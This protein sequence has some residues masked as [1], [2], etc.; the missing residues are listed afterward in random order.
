MSTI[1]EKIHARVSDPG[2][3]E[4]VTEFLTALCA[5]DTTPSADV[6]QMR[7][8]ESRAFDLIEEF[9]NE[10][11]LDEEFAVI[12]T[13][14]RPIDPAIAQNPAFS[15]LHF[16]KTEESP[17]GLSPEEVYAK[18]TNL[19]AF[20][21]GA[22]DPDG[23]DTAINAH[24]DVIAP[25]IPPRRDG[26]T[27]YG[28]G[29]V[30]DKGN[31]AAICAAL[32]VIQEMAAVGDIELKNKITAMFPVEEETGGNGSLA[33][34]MDRELRKRYDSILI[35]E[36]AGG[37]IFP[38]N[39]G[40]VWFKCG[41]RM[42]QAEEGM[43][44]SLLYAAAE[45]ILAMSE[46]GAKI[47]A[48]SDH[49]LFPHRPVQTCNGIL[50]PYGE[51]PS[52]INGYIKARLQPVPTDLDA[53][54]RRETNTP[55]DLAPDRTTG[56]NAPTDLAS[57]R[58]TG[59]NAPTDL[60]SDRTSGENAPTDL[61]P[62]R[63]TGE[64]AP[65]D[66]APVERKINSA[67]HPTHPTQSPPPPTQDRAEKIRETLDHALTNYIAARGDKTKVAD[68]DTGK[69]KV[70][71]HYDLTEHENGAFT[72]EVYGST[73]HM[74]AILEHDDAI[75]KWAYFAHALDMSDLDV[76]IAFEDF[77]TT[78][79]LVLEGGQGFLPTHPIAHIQERMREACMRGVRAYLERHRL[80]HDVIA[81]EV[82][83][84]KLHNDAFAGDSQ[85]PTMES[86]RRAGTQAGTV[87]PDTPVRGWDVSCDARLFA[88]EYPE[89]P[90]I[91]SGVGT[92]SAAHS[93]N[94]HLKLPELWP[95][96]EFVTRFLLL[97]TGSE[98]S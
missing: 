8:Q 22:P 77:D 19:L 36:C 39:R 5:V 80:A 40:A 51:H 78:S 88:T 11:P 35:L 92:L 76:N 91:T 97:E 4:S 60:A 93:N 73:G 12:T 38:G 66:L 82:S 7:Q 47:K 71:R 41:F 75:L 65:T 58:T 24:I 84:D 28:R 6:E 16:T 31:V 79:N 30:D 54:Q 61:A 37:N 87:A 3:R 42:S 50:G 57:D 13:E 34:A 49:P 59:E 46:E 48:E 18:R 70:E 72:L 83:Y 95:T 14:R 21:D 23:C 81:V 45:A 63:T 15:K 20:L 29:T 9:L 98:Q 17:A 32:R 89:I 43:H 62:D 33:L 90:V 53:E 44:V 55:A 56:E 69:P 67:D 74:G 26:E 1:P 85:S 68:P 64:N 25:F 10:A 2:F 27:L 52:R 94:E 86:A 96:I